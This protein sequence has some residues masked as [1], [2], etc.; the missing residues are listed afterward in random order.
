MVYFEFVGENAPQPLIKVDVARIPRALID[1]VGSA[2]SFT[3]ASEE[4]VWQRFRGQANRF[5][6]GAGPMDVRPFL[7]WN[8]TGDQV[9]H[10]LAF[11]RYVWSGA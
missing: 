5:R 6:L 9:V 11:P 7:K 8:D 10:V 2:G 4:E 3:A 1:Y